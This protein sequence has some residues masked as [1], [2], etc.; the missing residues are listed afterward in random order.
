[1]HSHDIPLHLFT[2]PLAQFVHEAAA[3]YQKWTW[4]RLWKTPPPL[5]FQRSRFINFPALSVGDG[6]T[7]PCFEQSRFLIISVSFLGGLIDIT[8]IPEFVNPLGCRNKAGKTP[9]RFHKGTMKGQFVHA[10]WPGAGCKRRFMKIYLWYITYTWYKYVCLNIYICKTYMHIICTSTWHKCIDIQSHKI[11]TWFVPNWTSSISSP[12]KR[13][14]HKTHTHTR[15]P[16]QSSKH[17]TC[18]YVLETP[19]KRVPY[20]CGVY[21]REN[22]GAPPEVWF[23]E[24]K[25]HTHPIGRRRNLPSI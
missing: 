5:C 3:I 10:S 7:P 24:F 17:E 23:S 16:A 14:E 22:H 25:S 20:L 12:A 15:T 2:T 6:S 13:N 9:G 11:S 1:M 18:K 19:L 21:Q 8:P 4:Q